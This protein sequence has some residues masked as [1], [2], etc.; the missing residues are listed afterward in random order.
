MTPSHISRPKHLGI[1]VGMRM[2]SE[3]ITY[4]CGGIVQAAH[5]TGHL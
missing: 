5:V 3:L 4:P 2:G 1:A